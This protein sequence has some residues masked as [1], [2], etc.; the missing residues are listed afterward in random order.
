[1][2]EILNIHRCL[3]KGFVLKLL[4]E[5]VS[6]YGRINMSA[7]TGEW[8]WNGLWMTLCIISSWCSAIRFVEIKELCSLLLAMLTLGTGFAS[9]EI[10]ISS[11]SGEIWLTISKVCVWYVWLCLSV[12]ISWGEFTK[13][14]CHFSVH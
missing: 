7:L 2:K 4:W 8:Q 11:V 1:M 9:F 10:V 12:E 6:V 14:S 13:Q 3:N 5:I